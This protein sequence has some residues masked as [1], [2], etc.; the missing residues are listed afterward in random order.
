[1]SDESSRYFSR[2]LSRFA[3]I[4]SGERAWAMDDKFRLYAYDGRRFWCRRKHSTRYAVVPGWKA[5]T[6][7]WMHEAGCVC[8]ACDGEAWEV[9]RAA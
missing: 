7:G 9:P 6:Y 3:V 1:M 4:D 5:P 2:H 8:D